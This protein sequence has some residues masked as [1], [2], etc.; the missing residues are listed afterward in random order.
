MAEA[1]NSHFTNIGPDLARDMPSADTV[2]ESYLI[3]TNASFSFKSCS[4]TEVRKLLETLET[5][6]LTGQFAIQDA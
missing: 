2:P 3:S 1:F 6:K 5:K 4:S